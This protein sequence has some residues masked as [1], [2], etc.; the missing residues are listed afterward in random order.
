MAPPPASATAAVAST[1]GFGPR[2][3][4]AKARV[5]SVE[6]FVLDRLGDPDAAYAIERQGGTM[7]ALAYGVRP[8]LPETRA[9]GVGLL[10]TVQPGSSPEFSG[11]VAGPD[12][13]IEEVVVP[14]AAQALWITG[15]AHIAYLGPGDEFVEEN[16]RLAGDVLLWQ[17]GDAIFRLESAVGRERAIEIAAAVTPP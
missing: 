5:A 17:K 7:V 10:L 6:P 14:G 12:S 3:T 8:D 4:L 11:K 15:A 2:I 1:L 16:V 9:P 13:I